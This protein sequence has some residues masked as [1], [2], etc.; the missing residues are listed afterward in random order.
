MKI[1]KRIGIIYEIG[2]F[3]RILLGLF[4]L[5]I[6]SN[7]VYAQEKGK[8][9]ND[10]VFDENHNVLDE[11]DKQKGIKASENEALFTEGV[12]FYVLEEYQKALD[13][14]EKCKADNKENAAIYF[15]IAEC[16]VRLG[17]FD[18]AVSPA[19]K[20]IELYPKNQ[21]YYWL[22]AE[23]F[24]AKDDYKAAIKTYKQLIATVPIEENFYFELANCYLLQNK[25][26]DAIQ[27][28]NDAEKKFGI[29]ETTVAQKQKIYLANND[30]SNALLEGEK[31]IKSFPEEQDY[32]LAQAE[33]LIDYQKYEDAEKLLNKFLLT[34]PEDGHAYLLLSETAIGKGDKIKQKEYL[35][36]AFGNSTLTVD[37]KIT[38]LNTFYKNLQT[39]D[40][41]E[42][43]LALA[44]LVQRTHPENAKANQVYGDF[45]VANNRKKE[46]RD[47]YIES[48]KYGKDNYKI[49]ERIILFDFE[50]KDFD[51]MATHSD[52]VVELF[53]NQA[54]MWFYNGSAKLIKQQYAEAII[55]L[56]QAKMF[57]RNNIDLQAE[58]YSR[59]GDAQHAVKNYIE[60]DKAYNKALELRPD[61][62]EV[63]NNYSYYLSLRKEKLD[64]AKKMSAHLIELTKN[65]PLIESYLDTYGWVLFVAG[66]YENAK[67]QLEKAAK[68]TSNGV[69]LEHYGDVL[70]KLGQI[71]QA[72]EQWKKAKQSGGE[73]SEKLDKKI[74]EKKL[75][76]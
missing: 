74:T 42:T 36:K 9:K 63:L 31:L 10:V 48:L 70:F 71:E 47:A 41:R 40:I 6:C 53:P 19:E 22:L 11:T 26:E 35:E 24:K 25:Y 73:I 43:G 28:Y 75:L 15:K 67:I 72:V 49:W 2:R 57:S 16:Y 14:F 76:E 30:V 21:Y 58:I 23:T 50:I 27:A 59:L 12:K 52:Q 55:S 17:K 32:W 62:V 4:V 45:L 69:I 7:V 5:G 61:N 34:F 68:T 54:I 20:A 66:E 38:I 64:V 13:I 51:A 60:S 33:L 44:A 65:S 3:K 46:A 8:P 56:E 39:Q 29:N 37:R 1:A 18:K